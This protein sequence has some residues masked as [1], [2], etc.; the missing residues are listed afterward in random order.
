MVAEQ[1]DLGD[2][3][4]GDSVHATV[5]MKQPTTV[6]DQSSQTTYHPKNGE[7]ACRVAN[8]TASLVVKFVRLKMKLQLGGTRCCSP[9]QRERGLIK[10]S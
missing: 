8:S 6:Q 4:M 2:R 1:K 7:K 3:A 10:S 5:S 9:V